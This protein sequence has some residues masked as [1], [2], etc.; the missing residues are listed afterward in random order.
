MKQRRFEYV[1]KYNKCTFGIVRHEMYKAV[2]SL[3]E[4]NCRN[5]NRSVKNVDK[6]DDQQ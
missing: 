3:K 4:S 2:K 5:P 1:I 6:W